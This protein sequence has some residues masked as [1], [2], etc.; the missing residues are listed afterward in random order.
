MAKMHARRR[1][2]SGSKKPASIIAPAWVTYK[3]QEVEALV[4][5]LAKQGLTSSLIGIN[6]RDSYGIP[7]VEIITGKKINKILAEK[8]LLP[9]LPQDLQNLMKRTIIIKKHLAIHKKDYHSKRGLQLVE[10]KITR[11][12]K[13]YKS[14]SVLPKDWKY[15]SE[16]ASMLVRA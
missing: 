16:K 1:G 11:L 2:K 9:E 4:V 6:L 12:V 13:Y 7:D 5:K 15:D 10:A 8:E 3:P 14:T